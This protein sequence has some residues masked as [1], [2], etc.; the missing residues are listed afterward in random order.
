[1]AG[2][3]QAVAAQN[4]NAGPSGNSVPG[5]SVAPCKARK[6][7]PPKSQT[8][9]PF[10]SVAAPTHWYD[11]SGGSKKQQTGKIKLSAKKR[12]DELGYSESGSFSAAGAG[13]KFYSDSQCTQQINPDVAPVTY[14]FAALRSGVTVYCRGD[15]AG[16]TSMSLTL[17]PPK[18]ARI[19]VLGPV[20]DQIVAPIRPAPTMVIA[21]PKIIVVSYR[22]HGKAK[23][24]VKPHRIPIVL[25]VTNP[26]GGEGV[27]T[28]NRASGSASSNDVTLFTDETGDSKLTMP[29]T[30]PIAELTAGKT[31]WAEG[32][33]PSNA[34]NGTEFTLDL[35]KTNVGPEPEEVK[36]KLT[37]VRL[38][39]DIF[40]SRPEDD[41]EPVKLDRAKRIEPGRYLLE[42]GSTDKTLFAERA[43]LAVAKAE[44][45]DFAGKVLV[46][47]LTANVVFFAPDKEKPADGQPVLADADLIWP[48]ATIDA[49][50]GKRFWL[51]GK[52]KS[53][54]LA[55]T[56]VA[57]YL[58]DVPGAEGDRITL[59]VLK[60][61]LKL[62]K[63]RVSRDAD[64][65]PFTDADKIGIG[66]YL[67]VQDE[68]FQHGRSRITI[69]KVV[70]DGFDGT[71]V[72]SGW[73]ITTSPYDG[74]RTKTPKVKLYKEEL[75]KKGQSAIAL[76]HEIR[77]PASFDA[78]GK[79][80]WIE[81]ATVC[82]DLLDTQLRLGVKEADKGCDRVSFNTIQ[83]KNLKAVIPSTPPNTA[84][85]DNTGGNNSPV[86]NHT[87]DSVKGALNGKDF[88]EDSKE[89]KPL[90]LIEGSVGGANSI[91]LS[92]E[93]EPV[94]K[95]IPVRWS[96]Q[97]DKRKG[98][99]DAAS[100]IS[101]AGNS[102][103]PGLTPDGADVL[104]AKLATAGVGTYHIRPYV[105][106]N[107]NSAFDHN[108]D[109]GKRIDREPFILFNLVLVRAEG[110]TNLTTANA[111][112]GTGMTTGGGG[113]PRGFSSGDFKGK[114][115]DALD[116]NATVRVI[117]GGSDGKRGL[118]R[119]FCGWVNN[120]LDCGT[121]PGPGGLGEDVTHLFAQL[122]PPL[123]LAPLP[124]I[125]RLRCFWQLNGVE[126]GG[127][128]L[129]SG[130]SGQGTGGHSCCGT[131]GANM[132]NGK[133]KKS[134]HGSG[135]GQT[136]QPKNSDSPGG[137]ITSISAG[138]AQLT[139]FTFN[140]D[141]RCDLV[142]WTSFAKDQSQTDSPA[143]RLYSTVFSNTWGI[144]FDVAFSPAWVVAVNAA[145]NVVLVSGAP[146]RAQPVEG[147]GLET[148]L[149]DGL[150]MLQADIPF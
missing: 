5:Q 119:V 84:R 129:D 134:K 141:F 144:R 7:E 23:P 37:C 106:C 40:K 31:V 125:E 142:F 44:P 41:S 102:D 99:G 45:A 3:S 73:D 114:G 133:V 110:I 8:V 61:E 64:P 17:A 98:D 85:A 52:T 109:A 25:G 49:T 70:P 103:D 107:D 86:S 74:T 36:D 14:S 136:W 87:F 38:K 97:R 89:N 71:L 127:P 20:A 35:R 131:M 80:F 68:K 105:D 58:E 130:Y 94:G 108:T 27:L 121:S 51:E 79:A 47:P 112:A 18:D 115:N 10:V 12:G 137:G 117:G 60:A 116:M 120:E 139:R 57:V 53:A 93:V 148:R 101:L 124:A 30:V 55:D 19:T 138:G 1:M 46:R 21:D 33:N 6:L 118:D 67:H 147:N 143:C 126:V 145:K 43:R 24:G 123:P 16:T 56:G 13:V 59:T 4:K 22:Y 104:K 90:V 11:N 95:N 135:I 75:P 72:L 83:F 76:P 92:V 28:C 91:D 113:R 15:L 128:V 2:S 29:L 122:P 9:E 34:V 42:Q 39:L 50:D 82:T 100:I 132:D 65:A 78:K 111:A 88:S 77:H 62:H 96:V 54:D 150:N 146:G 48:N 63:S 140:I 149:P 69:C 66:R 26:G 81:G 32:L